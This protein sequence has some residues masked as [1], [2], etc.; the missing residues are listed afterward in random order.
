MC[1]ALPS[2]VAG[3]FTSAPASSGAG[4]GSAV[5]VRAPTFQPETGPVACATPSWMA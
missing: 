5:G 3:D 4:L 2:N 1:I